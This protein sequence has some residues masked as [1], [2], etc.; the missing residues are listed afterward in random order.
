ML[1]DDYSSRFNELIE[2]ILWEIELPRD[3]SDFFD[4]RGDTATFNGDVRHNRR[5][6]V[7]TYGAL[8]FD[9]PIPFRGAGS[10]LA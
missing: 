1:E 5:M 2:S 10:S 9:S 4:Q 6:M 8:W 7:R 3:W